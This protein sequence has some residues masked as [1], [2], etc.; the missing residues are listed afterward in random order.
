MTC[1]RL[2]S[3]EIKCAGKDV[4]HIKGFNEEEENFHKMVK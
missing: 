3:S 4:G 1:N 2:Q